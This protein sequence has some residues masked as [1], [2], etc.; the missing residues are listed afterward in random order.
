MPMPSLRRLAAALFVPLAL[1]SCQ[2]TPLHDS[3]P[4]SPPRSSTG[5]GQPAQGGGSG[6]DEAQR[7]ADPYRV[8]RGTGVLVKGQTPF[9]TATPGVAPVQQTGSG[10]VLNFEG[11][12]LR[13][14]IRNVLGEILNESYTIDAGVGG[15]VT[16]RTTTGIPRDSLYATL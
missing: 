4:A 1:A 11:A 15:Q 5:T 9:G 6:G 7:G 8:F 16:I 10:I 3:R 12:D 13:E 14:V 2:T